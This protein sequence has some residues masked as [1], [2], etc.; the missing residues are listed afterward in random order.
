MM[1]FDFL[2]MFTMFFMELLKVNINAFHKL[3]GFLK[4][5]CLDITDGHVS[6]KDANN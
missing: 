6:E 4:L 3:G 1:L 2:V 5:D